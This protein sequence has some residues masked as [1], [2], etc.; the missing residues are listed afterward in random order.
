ME[1]ERILSIQMLGGFSISYNGKSIFHGK[2]A[3]GKLLQLLLMLV[4]AQE[5]GIRRERVLEQLYGDSDVER[6]SDS[7]R[8]LVYRLRRSLVEEGLPQDE[9]IMTQ[10]GVYRFCPGTVTV[11]LDVEEFRRKAAAGLE[12]VDEAR[13]TQLLEEACR[14]YHGEFLPTMIGDS[15]VASENW[16]FQE[17][18][19]KCM[20][21]LAALLKKQQ[22]YGKLLE[23]CENVL[24][25]YPY[26]EWQ[27][28]KLDCLVDMKEYRK[29][30]G[31]YD[32]VVEEYH[33]QF[34]MSP[35]KRV[36]D[37][38]RNIRNMIQFELNGIEEIQ[39]HMESGDDKRG[40]TQ[41][42]Y[43]SFIDV[44]RHVVRMMVR[45]KSNSY[46]VLFTI[47][48]RNGL[49]Y[50]EPESLETVRQVADHV[51]VES[52]R[53]SDLFSRYGKNQYLVLVTDTDVGGCR[54]VV[55]R[56]VSRFHSRYRDRKVDLYYTFR[57]A[58]E[59]LEGITGSMA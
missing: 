50:E 45:D 27:L 10:G 41:C 22:Q 32:E 31:Y 11:V 30:L 5:E 56:I 40:A 3:S 8:A 58:V 20:R 23:Y 46:L 13:R 47:V 15:W 12:E 48:G 44:Y 2:S 26:E 29:A 43:L 36:S 7:L 39:N 57:P 4:Y 51:F 59:E 19:F 35:S 52:M 42:D 38:G 54:T 9:Y 21:E 14:M 55:D 34:G 1:K 33:R 18:Y 6:A 28:L 53:C 37:A 25:K 24:S 49:P 17:L 16:R